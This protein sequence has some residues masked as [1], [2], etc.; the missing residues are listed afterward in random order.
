MAAVGGS[1]GGLCLHRDWV[2]R[3]SLSPIRPF[4]C[5]CGPGGKAGADP[6]W[7][8]QERRLWVTLS[9]LMA[10]VLGGTLWA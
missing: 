2:G 10:K 8:T 1:D 4:S 5:T 6:W 9:L 7:R 3:A